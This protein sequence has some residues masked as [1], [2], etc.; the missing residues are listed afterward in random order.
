MS[1]TNDHQCFL[2]IQNLKGRTENYMCAIGPIVST[3][4]DTCRGNRR[5]HGS[6]PYHFSPLDLLLS[7]GDVGSSNIFY[8]VTF[9]NTTILMCLNE[10]SCNSEACT[11]L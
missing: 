2:G 11:N 8:V 9:Q 5:S 10:F 1:A 3:S 4:V 6:E 7:P